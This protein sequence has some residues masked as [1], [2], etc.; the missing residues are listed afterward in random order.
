MRTLRNFFKDNDV[1]PINSSR[2][3][4]LTTWTKYDI[5]SSV[6]GGEQECLCGYFLPQIVSTRHAESRNR[7]HAGS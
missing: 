2:F 4:P 7:T 6:T 1:L 5:L 3:S